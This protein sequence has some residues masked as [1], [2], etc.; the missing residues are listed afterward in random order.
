MPRTRFNTTAHD[1]DLTF[2]TQGFLKNHSPRIAT[3]NNKQCFE[4]D[5]VHITIDLSRSTKCCAS[6]RY[7]LLT[8]PCA[9]PD[10]RSSR[11]SKDYLAETFPLF[12]K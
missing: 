5:R 8:I 9:A 2:P 12:K 3:Q 1:F 10:R 11:Y 7:T 4:A 6:Q